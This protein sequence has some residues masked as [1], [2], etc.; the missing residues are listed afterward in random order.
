MAGGLNF[1]FYACARALPDLPR[2]SGYVADAYEELVQMASSRSEPK[3]SE[4]QKAPR[5]SARGLRRSMSN[6]ISAPSAA[7]C[8]CSPTSCAR[9]RPALHRRRPARA[10]GAA[11]ADA[12]FVRFEGRDVSYAEMNARA[13][14]IAHWALARGLRSGA[15]VALLMENRPSTSPCGWPRQGGGDDGAAQHEPARRCARA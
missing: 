9:G 1:G 10:R 4:D 12:A 6:S 15:V 13:N 2:L 11:P 3:A 14:R 8:A 5:D 7:R